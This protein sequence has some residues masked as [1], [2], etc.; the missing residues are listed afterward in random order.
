MIKKCVIMLKIIKSCKGIKIVKNDQKMSKN[1]EKW[2]KF[3]RSK[4]D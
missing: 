4:N 3:M 1:D 2:S